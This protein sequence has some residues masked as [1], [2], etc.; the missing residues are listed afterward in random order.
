[1][2]NRK[3]IQ[4]AYDPDCACGFLARCGN[5]VAATILDFE[6]GTPENGFNMGIKIER[7]GT[8]WDLP[9]SYW[10]R[11]VWTR[12]LPVELKNEFRKVFGM[13]PIKEKAK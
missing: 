3:T 4:Y 1:M 13:K 2:S 5:E 10:R 12:K 6:S 7:C 8:I 11:L 9:S